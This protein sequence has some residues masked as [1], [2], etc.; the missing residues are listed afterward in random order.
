M[1]K[2]N[3]NLLYT[4]SQLFIADTKMT[5]KKKNFSKKFATTVDLFRY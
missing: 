3:S 5:N 4:D 1:I 2:K